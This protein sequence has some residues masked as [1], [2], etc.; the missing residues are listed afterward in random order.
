MPQ[1][2]TIKLTFIFTP[3]PS[4][5]DTPL[6]ERTS[7]SL[8]LSQ[9]LKDRTDLQERILEIA[10]HAAPLTRYSLFIDCLDCGLKNHAIVEREAQSIRLTPHQLS[11]HFEGFVQLAGH[12]YREK[13]RVHFSAPLPSPFSATVRHLRS[14]TATYR[15]TEEQEYASRV[16][17]FASSLMALLTSNGDRWDCVGFD[18]HF[19]NNR[20][21]NRLNK[22][23]T[24]HMRE[25]E[26]LERQQKR[27]E[28]KLAAQA[29]KAAESPA[30]GPT[31]H[32]T[33]RV[34]GAR[35]G[36]YKGVQMRSQ[37]EIAFASELDER[38]INW[39]YEGEALGAAQYLIDFY[40]P[41]LGVWVEVKGRMSPKDRQVL[42][43]VAAMLKSERQQRLL[44]YAGSGA[45]YVINPSGF[46]EIER[47]NF[48]SEVLK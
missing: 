31:A 26:K 24:K 3:R 7:T 35:P 36:I 21:G 10:N 45:C 22:A 29:A 25:K 18:P 42:P 34:P 6:E 17:A 30:D 8:K 19:W 37:L 33:G 5:K 13:M 12:N 44:L 27:L 23:A 41:D 4:L 40:L 16:S 47:K 14:L 46:R 39:V 43:E 2:G 15:S 38:G 32:G 28:A 48:W 9:T 20:Q 1:M 11:I